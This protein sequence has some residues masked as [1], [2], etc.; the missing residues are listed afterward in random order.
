MAF[1][2]NELGYT[3]FNARN[4]SRMRWAADAAQ[5]WE[6]RTEYRMYGYRFRGQR[7]IVPARDRPQSSKTTPSETRYRNVP[8]I[9]GGPP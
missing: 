2:S 9:R 6:W 4:L 7:F 1:V 3:T 5:H 8:K